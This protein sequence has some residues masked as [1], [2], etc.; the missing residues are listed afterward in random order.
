MELVI[1]T[2]NRNAMLLQRAE[3]YKKVGIARVVIIENIKQRILGNASRWNSIIDFGGELVHQYERKKPMSLQAQWCLEIDFPD[4]INAY[5]A[6]N[7]TDRE[8]ADYGL[9]MKDFIKW[10]M[11]P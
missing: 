10:W 9:T 4:E 5:I 6:K 8:I 1:N 3:K 2:H 11:A 7:F